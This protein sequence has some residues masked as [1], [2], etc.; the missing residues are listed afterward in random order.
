M[1]V[2]KHVCCCNWYVSQGVTHSS[3]GGGFYLLLNFT[4]APP[5]SPEAGLGTR[6]GLSNDWTAWTFRAEPTILLYI[7]PSC[8]HRTHTSMALQITLFCQMVTRVVSVPRL[9]HSEEQSVP[10]SPSMD[11]ESYYPA[12]LSLFL[13]PLPMKMHYI[14]V[15]YLQQW[16]NL[17][18]DGSHLFKKN[19]LSAFLRGNMRQAILNQ[20]DISAGE[21]EACLDLSFH[22]CINLLFLSLSLSILLQKASHFPFCSWIS[23]VFCYSMWRPYLNGNG[24]TL[25]SHSCLHIYQGIL[26]SIFYLPLLSSTSTGRSLSATAIHRFIY[27]KKNTTQMLFFFFC[28]LLLSVSLCPSPSTS[29]I[30]SLWQHSYLSG[31]PSVF[32]HL[33]H[34][35]SPFLSPSTEAFFPSFFS[36]FFPPSQIFHVLLHQPFHGNISPPFSYLP[37]LFSLLFSYLP[38]SFLPPNHPSLI[39]NYPIWLEW[40]QQM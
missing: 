2:F 29:H 26:S 13:S 40:L 3:G 4:K 19:L 16:V 5:Y 21:F 12:I 24:L 28:Y 10:K 37:T 38:S 25:T 27:L 17:N 35:N 9:F 33:S 32:K 23:S 1:H 30:Y 20:C 14:A 18:F 6:K 22:L 31:H 36:F 11:L 8:E 15:Y 34:M 7:I 39:Q